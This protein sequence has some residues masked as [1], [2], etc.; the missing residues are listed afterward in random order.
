MYDLLS[1]KS[2]DGWHWSEDEATSAGA[3]QMK[4]MVARGQSISRV[5]QALET[6]HPSDKR[7]HLAY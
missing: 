4:E 5:R 1:R 6:E 7:T 2:E 3:V